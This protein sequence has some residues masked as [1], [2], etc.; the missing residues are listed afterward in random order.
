M[1]QKKHRHDHN[2]DSAAKKSENIEPFHDVRR[3]RSD[4]FPLIIKHLFCEDRAI[5]VL[6]TESARPCGQIAKFLATPRVTYLECPAGIAFVH[7]DQEVPTK[8]DEP[9]DSSLF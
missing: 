2:G 1:P 7:P 5:P 6:Q 9:G 3:L 4:H 8:K